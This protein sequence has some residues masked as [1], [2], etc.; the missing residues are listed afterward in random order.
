MNCSCSHPAFPSFPKLSPS[1]TLRKLWVGGRW[2]IRTAFYLETE[3]GLGLLTTVITTHR[4]MIVEPLC[5]SVFK[6]KT[7]KQKKTPNWP[8]FL[9]LSK[10]Y[11]QG[12][13]WSGMWSF[14][15]SITKKK[16][17]KILAHFHFLPPTNYIWILHLRLW[18]LT[19]EN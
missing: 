17:K 16:K 3:T 19:S 1:S 7:K 11:K 9:A 18:H 2:T 6:K 8:D 12:H 5:A 15:L 13:S 4:V 14:G 10:T